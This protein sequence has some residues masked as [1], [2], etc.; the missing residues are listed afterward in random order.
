MHSHHHRNASNTARTMPQDLPP[1]G[2]YE[3]IQYKVRLF[4]SYTN[5]YHRNISNQWLPNAHSPSPTSSLKTQPIPIFLRCSRTLT[6]HPPTSTAQPPRPRL[7]PL[8]LPLRHGRHHGLWLLQSGQG[9]S[10]TE[11]RSPPIITLSPSSG[12]P[13]P[14]PSPPLPSSTPPLTTT[15]PQLKPTPPSQRARP[16]EDV[17]AHPPDPAPAGGRGPRP[18]AQALRRR[19]AREGPAGDGDERV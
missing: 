3:P 18:G 16:R 14:S 6:L 19:G 2:G 8:I 11:V 13:S 15:K 1:T 4:P 17:V 10:R 9:D 7:P 12:L 5:P